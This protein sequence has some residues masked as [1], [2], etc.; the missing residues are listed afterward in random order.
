[1]NRRQF[2]LTTIA[3]ATL[4]AQTRR[5]PNIVWIMADDLGYG[6]LGCYG[7]K[8]IQTPNIDRLAKEGIRFTNA[9]SG[10]TVCAPSRSVL[11]TGLH[12]GHTSIRSN[13]GGVPLLASDYTV[14]QTLKQ[15]GYTCGC[16]GKWGL[17]DLKT[18]GVPSKHGFDRFYGYLHQVHAHSQ[19]PGFLIEDN[20]IVPVYENNRLERGAYANDLCAAAALQFIN[21]NAKKPFFLYAPFTIPH[22]ELLAPKDSVDPYSEKIKEPKTYVDRTG[23]YANQALPLATYAGMIS[24]L[25]SYVGRIMDALK[26]QN[27]DQ[28]TIVFFTSDNGSATPLW[29]DGGFFNSTGG[30]RGHK[31]NFYE[32]GI[33]V[34]MIARWP[35]KIAPDKTSDFPWMFADFAPTAAELAGT[36]SPL[37][38]DGRSVL[39]TLLGGKQDQAEFLYWE[40]PRYDVKTGTFPDEIPIQAVRMGNWKAV[41]PKPGGTLELYNLKS[42]PTES[43]DVAKQELAILATIEKYLKTARTKPRTQKN[44]PNILVPG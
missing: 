31:Q 41:R 34:P 28:D 27:L 16:F 20:E 35:G 19:Y 5:K 37:G 24:R 10:C 14:A 26:L 18:D 21:E 15:A 12:M 17:G 23:H 6:D 38:I 40:L 7:Q 4:P 25:D 11:M 30:L 44:P 32:G 9:Y 22:L 13:P 33:R 36:Q 39:P 8:H 29:D 42:D 1:M 2:L 43:K 3:A